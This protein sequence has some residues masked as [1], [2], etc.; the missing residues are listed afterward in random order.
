MSVPCP[1]LYVLSVKCVHT[2]PF[3]HVGCRGQSPEPDSTCLRSC[4][5][6]KMSFS[7]MMLTSRLVRCTA[8]LSMICSGL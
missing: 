2:H 8:A 5:P 6:E 1:Y 4:T 3:A 7:F